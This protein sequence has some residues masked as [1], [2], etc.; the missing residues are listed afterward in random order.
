MILDVSPGEPAV[1]GGLEAGDRVTAVGEQRPIT[2]LDLRNLLEASV[3]VELS[4]EVERDGAV[5]TLLVTP[6]DADGKGRIGALIGP[7]AL[8]VDLSVAQALRESLRENLRNS[9]MLFE[10]L[11]RMVTREVPLKSVS[12]PIG[13]AQ[14]ARQALSTSPRTVI[15]LLAF[16]SLQLGILNLLP[17]PVLDGGH[18]LILLVEGVLRR[19]LPDRVKERVMQAGLLFLLVFMSLIIYLDVTKLL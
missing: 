13:I 1:L 5:R 3:G 15:W 7:V 4:V 12:G 18:I 11:K 10:V 19:E 6:R 14:Y 8:H 2:E 16:F 17:I 9:L